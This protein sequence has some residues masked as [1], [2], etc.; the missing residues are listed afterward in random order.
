MKNILDGLKGKALL[1]ELDASAGGKD[2]G[3]GR[4]VALEE[5]NWVP[6]RWQTSY[7]AV[8]YC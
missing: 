5:W 6:Q 4:T 3:V 8:S 7:S 2:R 1:W